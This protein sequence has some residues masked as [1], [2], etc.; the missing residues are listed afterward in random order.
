MKIGWVGTGIMGKSMAEHLIR[1]GHS[2]LVYNR[3]SSKADPLVSLGAKFCSI[4]ELAS[5]SDVVF[6]MVGYPRDV[7]EVVLGTEGILKHLKNGSLLVDHTTSSPSLALKINEIAA[8]KNI[9]VLDAPV[10]G[11][12]VGAREGK[13][14]IM[15]GGSEQ[16]FARGIGLM[17]NYG[18]NVE[19]MGPCGAGQHTKITNQIVIAGNMIGMVEGL[20]YAVKAGLNANKVIDLISTG[21]A[22]S[23]SLKVLGPRVLRGDLEPGFFVEHFIKDLGMALEECR[24]MNLVLPG[25]SMVN[26]FYLSLAA[27]GEDK[28]GTQALVKVI[29]RLNGIQIPP[30]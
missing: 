12:D 28:K 27:N 16:A 3:T 18:L 11:G 14:A 23:F 8:K 4:S 7:E 2:L 19:L 9:D 24:R 17:K 26:Q 10:S 21:A 1:A 22:A 13:L 6:T 25:L 20:S 5:M 15:V 30:R 29:E